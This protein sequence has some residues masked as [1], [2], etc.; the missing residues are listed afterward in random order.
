WRRTLSASVD[1][2]GTIASAPAPQN[3]QTTS[4]AI[5]RR[6]GERFM[7]WLRGTEVDV[8][9]SSDRRRAL[10]DGGLHLRDRPGIVCRR[11]LFCQGAA[12]PVC[13]RWVATGRYPG[14]NDGGGR[15]GTS[16]SG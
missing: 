15:S 5:S 8:N 3:P 16:N 11:S 14:P 12:S 10:A 13:P 7:P 2:S 9:A 4:S 1:L 6:R